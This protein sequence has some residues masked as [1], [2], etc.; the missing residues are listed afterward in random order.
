[1]VIVQG[2]KKTPQFDI[3]EAS[4]ILKI[5]LTSHSV[6]DATRLTTRIMQ[7]HRNQIYKLATELHE[8][9]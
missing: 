7:G 4:R 3:Q 8:E 2:I 5:L 1:M 9:K 6:Q